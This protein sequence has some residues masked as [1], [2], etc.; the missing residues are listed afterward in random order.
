MSSLKE[1]QGIEGADF[2]ELDPGFQ[3]L[4]KNLLP[5]ERRDSVFNSLHHCGRLAG[6]R[7][8][9]L[10]REANKHEHLPKIVKFDRAGN[11][12]EQV[13][14]GTHARHLR[15]EVAEF[16][17]LTDA[18]NGLHKF[19]IVY[20]LAHN[21]EGSVNCGLS[22]TDGLIRAIE[23]VGSEFLRKTYLPLLRSADTP[24]AGAQFITEAGAGSDVGAVETE[25]RPNS[26][27]TWTITGLQ[28][29]TA[30]LD[31]DSSFSL[32]TSLMSIF[33]QGVTSAFTLD[34]TAAYDAITI[35]TA[36]R[37]VTGGKATFDLKTHRTV[38]GTD[39]GAHDVDK[40]VDIHADLTFNGDGTATLVL[41]G[42]HTF[43]INLKS[44]RCDRDGKHGN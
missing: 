18:R 25:A 9:D 28:S 27:G 13:D 32:D 11:A 39:M 36:D 19:A 33:H 29:P 10:A 12:V 8:N 34:A 38:T 5:A 26:D 16:G 41:D 42:T 3:T 44:G 23:A 7:W 17:V 31:G 2:F 15:R 21:G 30:T 6:G 20:L 14:Y 24:V 43:T 35:S 22:C 40:T 1:F 37:E 4:L